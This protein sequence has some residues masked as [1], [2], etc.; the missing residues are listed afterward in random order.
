MKISLLGW[1]S[2]GL[3][4]PDAKIDLGSVHSV[5][6]VSLIQMP[7]GTGKTTTLTL[8]RAALTGEAVDWD[9]ERVLQL[10]QRDDAKKT[11]GKFIL[12]LAIDDQPLIFDLHCDFTLPTK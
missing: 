5:P 6:K 12:R 7:N 1:E 8:I 9:R 2:E 3:R 11:S 10:Q 4:C